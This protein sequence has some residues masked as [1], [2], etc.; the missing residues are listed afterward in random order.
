MTE[1]KKAIALGN[2]D[3]IHLGHL[4]VINEV[5]K[6]S[7]PCVMLF[8][9]HSLKNL[10]GQAPPMLITDA[11]RKSFFECNSIEQL[12]IDFDSIHDMSPEQFVDEI[13]VR[14]FN[15]QAVVCGY[16]YRFGKNAEGDSETLKKLCD[17]RNMICSVVSEID[18][19]GEP[20]SSTRIRRL[21][22]KGSVDEANKMLSESYGF[23]T[24]VLHGDQRGRGW[25]FPTINQLLPKGF[26]M[27]AFG[28]YESSVTFDGKKYKGVTNIGR[29][30][31]IGTDQV[32]SETY[33]FD[34][35]R[36]VY[37]ENI[38][39]RLVRFIRPERK[40]SSFEELANQIKSDA[41]EVSENVQ[42]MG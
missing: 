19:D 38:D 32:L 4:A 35:D 29:R 27:P 36:D 2:F 5:K 24:E 9:E 8:T 10:V 40:F 39:I 15:A 7:Y 22:E 21:I 33:I 34:F 28:V 20:V 41:M 37:G 26:V 31:T 14:K 25:G 42:F 16:N 17:E 30:P 1:N 23:C 3:G 13:L 6:F 11:E 12:Y 18:F